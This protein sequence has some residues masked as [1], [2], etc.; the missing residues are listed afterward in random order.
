MRAVVRVRRVRARSIDARET[1]S[2]S[3]VAQN[4]ALDLEISEL[5]HQQKLLAGSCSADERAWLLALAGIVMLG[6]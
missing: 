3:N 5:R 6:R 1:H 2:A 4:D